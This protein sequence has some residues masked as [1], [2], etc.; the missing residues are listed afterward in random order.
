[1]SI[2]AIDSTPNRDLSHHT[3]HR[4]VKRSRLDRPDLRPGNSVWWKAGLFEVESV[5][6]QGLKWIAVLVR[7]GDI[8]KLEVCCTFA[9]ASELQYEPSV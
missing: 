5:E 8:G 3:R 1:M 4:S 7:P 6:L 9:P 2:E